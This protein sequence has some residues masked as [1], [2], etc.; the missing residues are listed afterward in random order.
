MRRILPL[1]L[2]LLG[3]QPLWADEDEQARRRAVARDRLVRGAKL[4]VDP[5]DPEAGGLRTLR[6]SIDAKRATW[7]AVAPERLS[8]VDAVVGRDDER[9]IIRESSILYRW[10]VGSPLRPPV[11]LRL[12]D[13]RGKDQLPEVPAQWPEE[14]GEELT[15]ALLRGDLDVRRLPDETVE[16]QP[17]AED[18]QGEDGI[19][20]LRG[21]SD[22]TEIHAL[23]RNDELREGICE[24]L[25]KM[26]VLQATQRVAEVQETKTPGLVTQAL[27]DEKAKRVDVRGRML[28]DVRARRVRVVET[29][30][31]LAGDYRA[32][33]DRGVQLRGEQAVAAKAPRAEDPESE[34]GKR[35]AKLELESI[36]HDQTQ[37][38]LYIAALRCDARLQLFDRA[39]QAAEAE[40]LAAQELHKRYEV[41]LDSRR[42]KEQ[43]D[44]LDLEAEDIADRVAEATKKRDDPK[45][46]ADEKPIWAAYVDWFGD[47]GSV[48]RR[49]ASAVRFRRGF[50]AQLVTATVEPK[51]RA[52]E[53]ASADEGVDPATKEEQAPEDSDPLSHLR[54]PAGKVIDETFV[55]A[56]QAAIDQFDARLVAAHYE[57]VDDRVRQLDAALKEVLNTQE[58]EQAFAVLLQKARTGLESLETLD[59]RTYW[60]Y[61][62]IIGDWKRRFIDGPERMFQRAVDG[63]K[64]DRERAFRTREVLAAYRTQLLGLG[65]RSFQVRKERTLTG[66]RMKA[67][68]DELGD[69]LR[70]AGRW[71]TLQREPNL[72]TF[73][74]Q[75]WLP[76]LGCLALLAASIVGV[77]LGRRR[78][79]AAMDRAAE[80]TPGLERAVS[81]EA[82]EAERAAEKEQEEAA[83]K[84]A[85]EAALRDVSKQTAEPPP[86]TAGEGL[87]EEEGG[88]EEDGGA[89]R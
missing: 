71:L 1:A 36:L 46:P 2:V 67:A 53:S 62:L 88:D 61:H 44:T 84:A 5:A 30:D 55:R 20:T 25:V 14:P 12:I 33:L 42:R 49:L 80:A 29:L 43:L 11:R 81:V 37:R 7:E 50:E 79:D 83:V 38:L 73:L 19:P 24:R 4:A 51:K 35:L 87:L 52:P 39:I 8:Q 31:S 78:I 77:R 72:G 13:P 89:E 18:A 70:L 74:G 82:E 63:L 3:V 76:L 9:G 64:S 60:R 59:Q 17:E 41:R 27:V 47:L 85:E 16:V 22:A 32:L 6:D 10:V 45:T 68:F 75:Q 21:L 57:A 66:P 26:R 86:G 23:T 28:D 34:N 69:K 15:Q 58:Q 48:N 56:A 54:D 65:A 40:L